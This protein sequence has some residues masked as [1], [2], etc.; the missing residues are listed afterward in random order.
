MQAFEPLSPVGQDSLLQQVATQQ[1][2][3]EIVS[4]RRLN[5]SNEGS[6][7]L[8]SGQQAKAGEMGHDLSFPPVPSAADT[9]NA[10]HCPPSYRALDMSIPSK[11]HSPNQAAIR[12]SKQHSSSPSSDARLPLDWN[13]LQNPVNMPI[14]SRCDAD[15]ARLL[16]QQYP[17][18]NVHTSERLRTSS[19]SDVALPSSSTADIHASLSSTSSASS[20]RGQGPEARNSEA[21]LLKELGDVIHCFWLVSEYR[22]SQVQDEL[23]DVSARVKGAVLEQDQ[24][25]A[26]MS[27]ILPLQVEIIQKLV[28]A[29]EDRELIYG[30][31]KSL[32]ESSAAWQR[33]LKSMLEAMQSEFR[34]GME[35]VHELA[36]KSKKPPPA[37]KAK[38]ESTA[39]AMAAAAS[40]ATAAATATTPATTT[41]TKNNKRASPPRKKMNPSN[42]KK[43]KL[44]S[45]KDDK[46]TASTS[47]VVVA[48]TTF[49]ISEA[50]DSSQTI[51]QQQQPGYDQQQQHHAQLQP[52]PA[53]PWSRE[54]HSQS[55]SQ[56]TLSS[57]Y[58]LSFEQVQLIPR[59]HTTAPYLHDTQPSTVWFKMGPGRQQD[60]PAR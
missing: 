28:R 43:A 12:A 32:E 57:H 24:I 50:L 44:S 41:A 2:G 39:S 54:N 23:N 42:G 17:M 11:G 35:V 49:P 40:T 30:R 20:G 9:Y 34:A 52:R 21:N 48:S 13:W 4:Q 6:V 38:S 37:P 36:A 5:P 10:L 3:F 31:I 1:E 26:H 33:G 58:D 59:P 18:S 22:M 47:S 53:E 25:S 27:Q 45:V 8:E 46:N 16:Q 55:H 51:H 15:K 56:P 60:A 29:A 19:Q 14:P 7:A